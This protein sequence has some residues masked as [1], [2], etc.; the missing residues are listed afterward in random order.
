MDP[1][2]KDLAVEYVQERLSPNI[3]MMSDAAVIDAMERL[4]PTGW[5]GF[6]ADASTATKSC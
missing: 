1:L 4:Y 5:D 6:L 3:V 2:L